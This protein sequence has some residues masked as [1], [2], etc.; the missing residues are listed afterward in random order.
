M[1]GV[2]P[3]GLILFTGLAML[4]AGVPVARVEGEEPP[5]D[6]PAKAAF[7]QQVRPVLAKYCF[8]CHGEKKQSTKLNLGTFS[9]QTKPQEWKHIWE[10]VR[11]RQMPPADQPQPTA[12]ERQQL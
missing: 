5:A 2:G 1:R 3:T 11:S 8:A 7:A 4:W 12:A 9:E 10:R 6:K